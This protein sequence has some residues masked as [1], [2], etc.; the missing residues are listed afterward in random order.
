MREYQYAT[1]GR[2][3][4]SLHKQRQNRS[5]NSPQKVTYSTKTKRDPSSTPAARD[6]T[7]RE[8]LVLLHH[9]VSCRLVSLHDARRTEI[10]APSTCGLTPTRNT[11]TTT[12]YYA[13]RSRSRLRRLGSEARRERAQRACCPAQPA[14]LRTRRR[15]SRYPHPST[16]TPPI[17]P[18]LLASPTV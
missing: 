4:V 1:P 9:R 12:H 13:S 5:P 2:L 18:S 11:A 15:R 8:L 3:I 6:T 16:R 14:N 7:A 17:H 10:S